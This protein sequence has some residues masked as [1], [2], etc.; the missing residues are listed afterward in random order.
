M[1]MQPALVSRYYHQAVVD[2]ID[3]AST[4]TN[5][6]TSTFLLQGKLPVHFPSDKEG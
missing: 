6:V 3:Y 4:H 5:I 1:A 2:K